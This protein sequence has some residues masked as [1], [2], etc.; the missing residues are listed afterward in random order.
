CASGDAESCRWLAVH[1]ERLGGADPRDRKRGAELHELACGG[2][3]AESCLDLG[4]LHLRGDG[5]ARGPARAL[6]LFRRACDTGRFDACVEA[7]RLYESGEAGVRDGPR[8][9]GLFE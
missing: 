2:G 7:A 5:V 6:T 9:V 8:A 1:L 4:R 3:V